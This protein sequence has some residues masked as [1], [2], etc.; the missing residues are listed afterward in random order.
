MAT[1]P[2]LTAVTLPE[3]LTV[4]MEGSVLV[5]CSES[6]CTEASNSKVCFTFMIYSFSL[7]PSHK[8]AA[9]TVT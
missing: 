7:N 2:G 6:R 8:G 4:A 5:H 1:R 3:S 9:S